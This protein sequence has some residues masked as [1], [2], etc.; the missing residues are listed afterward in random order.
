MKIT[1]VNGTEEKSYERAPKNIFLSAFAGKAEIK[2]W[3]L[4]KD[5]PNF[6]CGCATCITE[7]EGKCRDA[8]YFMPIWKSIEAAD[9]VVFVS[10]VYAGHAP[11]ALKN[12]LDHFEWAWMTHRPRRAMFGKR[13]FIIIDGGGRGAKSA[14]QDIIDSL[15]WW[16][17]AEVETFY[18][19]AGHSDESAPIAAAE[20]YLRTDFN[21]PVKTPRFLKKRFI[22]CARSRAKLIAS[23]TAADKISVDSEYWRARGWTDKA[24][25]W[26]NT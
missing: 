14:A 15:N 24:A 18:T 19:D 13:A 9:L 22:A 23:E 3:Y 17:I 25:P 26:K 21:T 20:K 6:C 12:L 4:P 1:V 7:G 8:R 16:G 11:A 10:P 2:E 5:M